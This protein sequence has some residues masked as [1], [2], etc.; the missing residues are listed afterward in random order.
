[1]IDFSSFLS[2][3]KSNA[4]PIVAAMGKHVGWND[5]ID[6]FGITTESLALVKQMLYLSAI[7]EKCR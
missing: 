3:V 4:K 6:D 5:H 7:S 2:D 1:M